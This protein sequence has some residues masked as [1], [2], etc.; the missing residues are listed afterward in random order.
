M[1]FQGGKHTFY[2]GEWARLVSL[3][4]IDKPLASVSGMRNSAVWGMGSPARL[5]QIGKFDMC[6]GLI[7]RA[8]V[9]LCHPL[10]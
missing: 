2:Q 6:G 1:M 10:I 5:G 4:V 9:L 7:P 3:G 8:R